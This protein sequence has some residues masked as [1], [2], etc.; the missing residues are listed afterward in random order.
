MTLVSLPGRTLERLVL[1]TGELS[2]LLVVEIVVFRM[3][4]ERKCLV[5]KKRS[6]SWVEWRIL[7]EKFCGLDRSKRVTMGGMWN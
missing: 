5:L 7:V 4:C 6:I 3:C 2:R 1:E